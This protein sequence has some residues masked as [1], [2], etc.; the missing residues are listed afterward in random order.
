MLIRYN[1]GI[2]FSQNNK[3]SLNSKKPGLGLTKVLVIVAA[4]LKGERMYN[5]IQH[6]LVL[7]QLNFFEGFI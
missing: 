4:L 7:N 6:R 1:R 5:S 3:N 2:M